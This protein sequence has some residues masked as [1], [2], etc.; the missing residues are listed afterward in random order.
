MN[1]SFVAGNS[2]G[3]CQ[4]LPRAV[5]EQLGDPLGI[6]ARDV[7]PCAA[8]SSFQLI[9]FIQQTVALGQQKLVGFAQPITIAFD[10]GT[11]WLSEPSGQLADKATLRR[12]LVTKIPSVVLSVEGPLAPRRFLLGRERLD[13]S[14][15]Y[16]LTSDL[17]RDDER[18]S[19]LVLVRERSRHA[20]KS[21]NCGNSDGDPSA[22]KLPDDLAHCRELV[23]RGLPAGVDRP[24]RP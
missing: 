15:D 6:E 13:S 18:A 10:P 1:G 3:S 19:F 8:Q 17:R 23:G 21:V 2:V 14:A 22:T 24:F 5:W 16:G 4:R 20:G 12:D 9:A 11:V 7:R